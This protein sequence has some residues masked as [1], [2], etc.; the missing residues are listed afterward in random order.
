MDTDRRA[1]LQLERQLWQHVDISESPTARL[2]EVF[3]Q[4]R[5]F[6]ETRMSAVDV[7]ASDGD[8]NE[9]IVLNGLYE[10]KVIEQDLR[11]INNLFGVYRLTLDQYKTNVGHYDELALR[12]LAETVLQDDGGPFGVPS[13]FDKIENVMVRQNLYYKAML[14]GNG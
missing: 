2:I 4:H 7:L 9:F 8:G 14:V 11:A 13:A 5:N 1:Y 6:T 10:W 12:D 3:G